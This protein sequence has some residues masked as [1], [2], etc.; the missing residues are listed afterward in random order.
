MRK[1]SEFSDMSNAIPEFFYFFENIASIQVLISDN[2][3]IFTV[4][5]IYNHFK[6]GVCA[7]FSIN[8]KPQFLI[9]E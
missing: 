9:K 4:P 2:M 1:I 6:L 3:L 8:I 7:V 5:I